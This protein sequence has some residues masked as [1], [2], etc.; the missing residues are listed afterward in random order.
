MM[1]SLWAGVSGLQAH[2]TAMDVEGNNIANVNTVGFKYSRT[3][4]ADMLSQTSKIATAPQDP[5]GGRNSLQVGLGASVSSVTHIFSQGSRQTTDKTTDVAIEG[6]GF[7]VVSPDNGMTYKYTRA[8]DFSF[9]AYGNFVDNNGLIVQGWVKDANDKI[10]STLPIK[11]IQI[12]PGMTIP[13]KA[14][15]NVNLRANLVSGSTTNEYSSIYALDS[16]SLTSAD[17]TLA[18]AAGTNQSPEDLGSLFDATGKA[19]NLQD[20]QGIWASFASAQVTQAVTSTGLTNVDI[21]INGIHI[22]GTIGYNTPTVSTASR[23]AGD[24]A[25]LINKA[26]TGVSASASGTSIVLTNANEEEGDSKKNILLTTNAGDGS[27]LAAITA[28]TPG[29]TTAFKYQYTT[30]SANPATNSTSIGQTKNFHTT[31]DLRSYMQWQAK[32]SS[33]GALVNV[34]SDGKYVV[35]NATGSNLVIQVTSIDGN[36]TVNKSPLFTQTFNALEGSLPPGSGTAISQQIN[37]AVHASSTDIYDSLGSKHTIT[38]S[39]RKESQGKWSWSATVPQPAD[40]GGTAPNQNVF[41]SGTVQFNSNGSLASV[42]PQSLSITWNNGSTANQQVNLAFGTP[43]TFD[44]LTSFDQKSATGLIGQDGYSGGDLN[45]VRIDQNGVLIGSFTNGRSL[46]LAQI[47]MAKFANNEGL[48]ADGGNLFLQSANSGEPTVGAAGSGG[49]GAVFSSALEMSNVDLSKSLTQLIVIQRGYQ[50]N[51]KT[52]TTSD[53][54]L[55]VLL[56]LKQ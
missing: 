48:M 8:G 7:F 32:A 28:A 10:D 25:D 26:K 47:S 24:L 13:A 18:N 12:D 21:T 3:N 16:D 11:S 29:A 44:G 54:M 40:L 6:D 51:S 15:Q 5:L 22:A 46:G 43:N 27:T 17:P 1:R 37:A 33:S 49:R 45:G 30:G 34:N 53:Q 2:Q 31:E 52:I 42:N 39:F 23:N 35:S 19:F 4:F 38:Y 41:T 36:G 56:Q 55:Q 14:T 50:A 20:G 9:D